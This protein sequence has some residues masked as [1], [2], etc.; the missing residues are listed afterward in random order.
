MLAD[1]WRLVRGYRSVP[2][3][4]EVESARALLAAAGIRATVE[5]G[6]G[7]PPQPDGARAALRAEVAR[8]LTTDDLGQ[9]VVLRIDGNRPA[10][11]ADPRPDPR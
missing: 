9:H 10:A 11:A 8:L 3:N 7:S 2:L 4:T 5:P 1:V 6:C